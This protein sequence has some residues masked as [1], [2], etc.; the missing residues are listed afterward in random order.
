M[1]S[2]ILQAFIKYVESNPKVVEEL[3]N[4]LVPALIDAI[5][6]HLK[7]VKVGKFDEACARDSDVSDVLDL[8]RRQGRGHVIGRMVLVVVTDDTRASHQPV[9]QTLRSVRE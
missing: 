5:V 9:C 4:Q 1:G 8:H 6:S 3:V 7:S 2:L